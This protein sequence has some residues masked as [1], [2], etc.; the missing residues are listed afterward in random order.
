MELEKDAFRALEDVVGPE[1]ISQD[2][3]IMDTYNQVWGNKLVFDE[4]G[5]HGRP[6]SFCLKPQRKSNPL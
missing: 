3:A 1:F 2:P 5:Q 4:N 6:Q